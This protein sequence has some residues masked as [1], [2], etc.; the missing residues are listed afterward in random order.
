MGGRPKPITIPD[1]VLRFVKSKSTGKEYKIQVAF[2]PGYVKGKKTY[3]V[4]YVL[5]ADFLFF[6]G[7]VETIRFL[8]AVGKKVKSK[9]T[10]M[11]EIFVV[12]IGY[13]YGS[14]KQSEILSEWLVERSK[15]L[16]PTA[17]R[18][19]PSGGANDFLDFIRDDLKPMVNSSYRTNPKDN[20]IY[21]ASFGALFALYVLFHRPDTFNRYVVLSPSLWWDKK[22]TF[23]YEREYANRHRELPARVF[24]SVGSLEDRPMA[25]DLLKL[26]RI[27]RKRKYK[28]LELDSHIYEG[29]S[30]LGA[31]EEA[32][33][34][35]IMSVFSLEPARW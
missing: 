1:T 26:V 10:V 4:L 7:I 28:G 34:R 33:I 30:H 13:P 12:G 31:C 24:L 19:R 9:M 15:D 11:P 17:V 32:K 8:A 5:D 29:V 2:P 27:L 22:V 25:Q 23:K 35:A 3:P 20:T 18:R 14:A 16:T 6:A 21:G